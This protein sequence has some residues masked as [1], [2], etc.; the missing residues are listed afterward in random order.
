MSQTLSNAPLEGGFVSAVIRQACQLAATHGR[1]WA[2][3]HPLVEAW[4]LSLYAPACPEGQRVRAQ[5]LAEFMTGYALHS[6]GLPAVWRLARALGVAQWGVLGYGLLTAPTVLAALEFD[7]R[8][9]P[10][11]STGL[12]FRQAVEGGQH[13][14]VAHSPLPQKHSAY[15]VF[16]LGCRLGLLEAA[17]G[18]AAGVARV[19]LPCEPMAGAQTLLSEQGLRVSFHAPRYEE[20]HAHAGLM[21]PNPHSSPEVHRLLAPV[22]IG[23]SAAASPD[24]S[25]Q[26]LKRVVREAIRADLDRGLSPTLQSVAPRLYRLWGTGE[27]GLRQLQ[28]RLAARQLGFREMVAEVRRERALDHLKHGTRPLAD[29]AAEAGYAELSSF[30]RAVR[31]WTGDTPLAYRSGGSVGVCSEPSGEA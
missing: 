6:G 1:S 13:Q 3:L 17:G 16:V 12:H 9:Q 5:C 10:L 15:W 23:M 8:L 22:A 20:T 18:S 21:S 19:S 11:A 14:C 27:I 25:D 2:I 24:A 4:R 29:I 26:S 31:R 7:E 28:R 30:H